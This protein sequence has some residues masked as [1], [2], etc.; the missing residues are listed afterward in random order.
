MPTENRS[1]NTEQMVSVPRAEIEAAAER[2]ARAQMFDF[3][4]KLYALLAQPAAQHQGEPVGYRWEQLGGNGWCYG[5]ALPAII[6]GAWQEL[7]THAAASEVEQ[8]QSQLIDAKDDLRTAISRNESLMRQLA[9][10]QRLL[11]EA[12][13]SLERERCDMPDDPL[14]KRIDAVLSASTEPA[15]TS[16]GFSAE[17]MTAQGAD[18]Y[19]NEI[20]A[21]AEL[22]E[23]YP[24]L[25]QAI[26]AL[27][28]PQ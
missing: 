21:A 22:A 6:I 17:Q 13:Y 12:S 5:E 23:A 16:D 14:T 3:S 18:G 2:F 4:S 10:Q 11:K 1:S 7:Y 24:E 9:E 19:R 27:P 28:L 26:R 20:K 8:L 15:P 25:A